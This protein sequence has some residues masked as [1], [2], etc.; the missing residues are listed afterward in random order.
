MSSIV[1]VGSLHAVANATG[2]QQT[3]S[4]RRFLTAQP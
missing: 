3:G 2:T 1:A 4:N